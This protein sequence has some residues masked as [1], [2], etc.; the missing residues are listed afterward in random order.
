ML[1][2]QEQVIEDNNSH[3]KEHEEEEFREAEEEENEEEENESSENSEDIECKRD[4][5]AYSSNLFATTADFNKV[6]FKKKH[7]LAD[8]FNSLPNNTLQ[9]YPPLY[10]LF[11]CLKIDC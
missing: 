10:I 6:L 9:S 5:S 1:L 8:Y 7:P 4:A 2:L 3:K 11:A